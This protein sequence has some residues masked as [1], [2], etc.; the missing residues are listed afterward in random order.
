[1]KIN[2][3]EIKIH[4]L[5][6]QELEQLSGGLGSTQAIAVAQGNVSPNVQDNVK[7]NGL[8]TAFTDIKICPGCGNE[9]YY[10]EAYSSG[11]IV[12]V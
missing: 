3:I 4:E 11:E 12:P 7:Y 8:A 6:E 1:M 10:A 5:T 9:Q 2:E